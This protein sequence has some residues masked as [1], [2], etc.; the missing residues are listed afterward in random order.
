[1]EFAKSCRGI[2]EVEAMAILLKMYAECGVAFSFEEV[3]D[4]ALT[5][6]IGVGQ[7][8]LTKYNDGQKGVQWYGGGL[9]AEKPATAAAI[10][11]K[12][13]RA[14]VLQNNVATF[15]KHNDSLPEHQ[16]YEMN[17]IVLEW[18]MHPRN[19]LEDAV[20]QMRL[21]VGQGIG[22]VTALQEHELN[23]DG[24]L[25]KYW[26]KTGIA[27]S[28][29]STLLFHPPKGDNINPFS[30]PQVPAENQLFKQIEGVGK[31]TAATA[32]KNGYFPNAD[33][34]PD[35]RL[36][37]NHEHYKD[38][39]N[40]HK[41]MC[42]I[43]FM[44]RVV[45]GLIATLKK[46]PKLFL[47]DD[48]EQQLA[49]SFVAIKKKEVTNV[50]FLKDNW[51]DWYNNKTRLRR[52]DRLT[53][54]CYQHC[55]FQFANPAEADTC[56]K[57]I[58]KFCKSVVDEMSDETSDE[59]SFLAIIKQYSADLKKFVPVIR[60]GWIELVCDVCVFVDL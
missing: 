13:T 56:R 17:K 26:K 27:A 32:L 21:I 60:E 22:F 10:K 30:A 9:S 58:S 36:D 8:L 46:S 59:Q 50:A 15:V 28:P 39:V 38:G 18:Q 6:F 48:Y 35:T 4:G 29:D 19:T 54:N 37:K 55:G 14:S 23:K 41:S 34:M 33:S 3:A 52:S 51:F 25:R 11:G 2:T 45:H 53:K 5:A 7:H 43:N 1:M 44:T 31:T 40:V 42:F 47:D 57:K 16:R 20:K 24:N 12:C 49:K